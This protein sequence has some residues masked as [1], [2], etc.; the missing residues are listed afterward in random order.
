MDKKETQKQLH[1]EYLYY[2]YK[3]LFYIFEI[4][5]NAFQIQVI[6]KKLSIPVTIIWRVVW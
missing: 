4:L 2:T 1:F 6:V 3:I 5:Q